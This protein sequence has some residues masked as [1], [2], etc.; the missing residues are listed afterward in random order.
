MLGGTEGFTMKVGVYQAFTLVSLVMDEHKK[1]I[2]GRAPW[3]VMFVNVV[4]L[5]GET[6]QV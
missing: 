6:T 3:F 5:V 4:V 1:E 2:Q